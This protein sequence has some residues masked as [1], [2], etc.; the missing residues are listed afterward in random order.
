MPAGA[1]QQMLYVY[2]RTGVPEGNGIKFCTC[3]FHFC[4]RSIICSVFC[5]ALSRFV[6]PFYC[7]QI[8]FG[9]MCYLFLKNIPRPI[10]NSATHKSSKVMKYSVTL[11]CL[12]TKESVNLVCL[13]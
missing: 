9:L 7:Q 12:T 13:I 5:I 6:G 4:V 11:D 3:A 8:V 10:N 2:E 1:L